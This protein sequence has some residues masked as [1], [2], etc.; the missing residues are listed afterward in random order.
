MFTYW[1]R[2]KGAELPVCKVQNA[3][4]LPRVDEHVVLSGEYAYKV[5][6]VI[7]RVACPFAPSDLCTH[8][9]TPAEGGYELIVKKV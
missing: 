3:L 5:I 4:V 6:Q 9:A 7:H 1:V 2:V 8:K